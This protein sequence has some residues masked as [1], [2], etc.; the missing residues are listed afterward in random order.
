VAADRGYVTNSRQ[1]TLTAKNA[2]DPGPDLTSTVVVHRAIRGELARLATLLTVMCDHQL[3]HRHPR[4]FRRYTAAV[5]AAIDDRG[6]HEYRIIW[7]VIAATARQAV[8]LALLTDDHQAIEAASGRARRALAMFSADPA[9]HAATLGASV[10]EMRDLLEEH[11]A[12]QE[13]QL[14]SVMRRYLPAQAYRWCEKRIARETTL[15]VLWF[16]VPWLARHARDGELRQLLAVGGWRARA[17]L[18]VNQ[19]R[20]GRLERKAFGLLVPPVGGEKQLST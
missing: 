1:L 9:T 3:E 18:A 12:D 17:L 4:E 6:Q 2:D 20:F 19:H 8:D 14:Y 5:L 11:I 16:G 10:S 13:T 7:P 15:R